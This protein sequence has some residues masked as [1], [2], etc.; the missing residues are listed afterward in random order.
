[1]NTNNTARDHELLQGEQYH[2]GNYY[3]TAYFFN[4]ES[5]TIEPE[6]CCVCGELLG[7]D[8]KDI[9]F[10]CKELQEEINKPK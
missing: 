8:E 2:R 3:D 7:V 1:M 5:E 9:C 4:E 10:E 6:Y